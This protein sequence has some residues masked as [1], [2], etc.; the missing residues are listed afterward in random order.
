MTETDVKSTELTLDEQLIELL[1]RDARAST[2]ALA[3]SLGVAR[4]TVQGRLERLERSGVIRG[5]TVLLSS[6]ALERQ[7]EAHVMISIEPAQQAVVERKLKAISAVNGL[8]TVSGAFDLIALVGAKSTEALDQA[9]D[10]LR[11]CPGVKATQ[12]AVILSRRLSR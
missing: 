6:A 12:T 1:R 7:V 2:A 9:L 10:E 11:A 3:R 4:S 8:F 5:Y